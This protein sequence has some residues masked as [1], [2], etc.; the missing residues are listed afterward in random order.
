MFVGGPY[1][2]SHRDEPAGTTPPSEL[3][4]ASA[5]LDA[6]HLSDAAGGPA[7]WPVSGILYGPCKRPLVCL[8]T[9]L[10]A[11]AFKNVIYLVDPGAPTTELSPHVFGALGAG[12][13]PAAALANINGARSHAR[14]NTQDDTP[15]LGADYMSNLHLTLHLDYKSNTVT[16]DAAS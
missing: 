8:P 9:A 15:V 10:G 5:L 7:T 1:N 6:E 11:G 13:A 4:E 3:A 2:I 14:L 12:A 16:L